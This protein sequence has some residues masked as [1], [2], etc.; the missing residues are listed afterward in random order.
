MQPSFLTSLTRLTPISYRP[1]AFVLFMQPEKTGPLG[2]AKWEG[3]KEMAS[4][5]EWQS[6]PGFASFRTDLV[7]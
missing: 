3:L 6:L 2:E 1:V 7:L 4:P 5:I